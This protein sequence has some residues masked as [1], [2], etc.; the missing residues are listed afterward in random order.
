LILDSN[1]IGAT[2]AHVTFRGYVTSSVTWPLDSRRPIPI[3]G[4]LESNGFRDI[5]RRMWRSC[6]RNLK[7]HSKQRSKVIHFGTN[8]FLVYDF[9]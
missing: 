9:L 4:P 2:S 6:S 1:R 5:Q 3:G 7:R 8:R